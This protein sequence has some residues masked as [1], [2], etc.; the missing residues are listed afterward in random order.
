MK[1]TWQV[2]WTL[3]HLYTTAIELLVTPLTDSLYLA[4]QVRE[5]R[6]HR[7]RG[8]AYTAR[9]F[10]WGQRVAPRLGELRDKSAGDRSPRGSRLR[11]ALRAVVAAGFG[12]QIVN[13]I[14][15]RLAS[16]TTPGMSGGL[17][18]S[19]IKI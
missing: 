16:W 4:L 19:A 6:V 13:S 5:V 7:T 17:I 1:I 9:G 2:V 3:C 12:G 11:L 8:H 15:W 18:A 10:E 14:S